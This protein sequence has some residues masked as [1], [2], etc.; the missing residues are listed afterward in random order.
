MFVNI[1]FVFVIISVSYIFSLVGIDY[2][3][4]NPCVHG[5]CENLDP[6]PGYKCICEAGY[7]GVYCENSEK[8][9]YNT[10]IIYIIIFIFYGKLNMNIMLK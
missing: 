3:Q 10:S 5:L 8:I 9:V 1:C 6:Q 2:C 4:S 7:T